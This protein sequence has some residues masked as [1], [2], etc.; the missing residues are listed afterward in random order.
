MVVSTLI[1]TLFIILVG[2]AAMGPL[3]IIPVWRLLRQSG[4]NPLLSL[5]LLVPY[6]G[7][8]SVVM[9]LR[10]PAAD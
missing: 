3:V 8:L 5:V 2:W 4:R 10:R 1:S 6:A 9:I 7:F